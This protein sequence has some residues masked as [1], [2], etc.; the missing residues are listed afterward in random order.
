MK[1]DN[2]QWLYIGLIVAVFVFFAIVP[3]VEVTVIN[4]S[5]EVMSVISFRPIFES[6]SLVPLV[7]PS[8]V[9]KSEVSVVQLGKRSYYV[10]QDFV[11][12]T[13]AEI[14]SMCSYEGSNI[15]P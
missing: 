7:D 6:Q 9:A 14:K 11:P 4:K 1:L 2:R 12:K 10:C 5:G 3:L 8:E 13:L 15:I